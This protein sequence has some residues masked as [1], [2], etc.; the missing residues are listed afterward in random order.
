MSNINGGIADR[1]Q[2]LIS[3]SGLKIKPLAEK[4][5]ISTGALS[6]YQNDAATPGADAI[7]KITRGQHNRWVYPRNLLKP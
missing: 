3:E 4:I 2:D 5:G 7:P 6:N 1:L